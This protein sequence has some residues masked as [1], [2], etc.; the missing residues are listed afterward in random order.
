MEV[1]GMIAAGVQLMGLALLHAD[2]PQYQ[3]D[4]QRSGWRYIRHTR[5]PGDSAFCLSGVQA[6][7][8][9]WFRLKA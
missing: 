8:T 5:L 3:Y 9:T 1:C 7:I 2:W 4:A 6:V